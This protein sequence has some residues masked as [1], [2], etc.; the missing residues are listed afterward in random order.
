MQSIQ[1]VLRIAL[2]AATLLLINSHAAFPQGSLTP[3]AAPAPTM[4]SLDQ[5]EARTPIAA[6]PFTI[7]TS[8][9]YYLTKNVSV[10]SGDAI[11]I[12]ANDVTLD[13]NGFTISSTNAN[14]VTGTGILIGNSLHNITISNGH[15]SGAIV[16]SAGSYSGSGFYNGIYFSAGPPQATRIYGV[17]V[18]GCKLNGIDLSSVS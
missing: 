9:S 11:T 14:P 7:T 18:S 12:N 3:Q 6:A 5:I 1:S 8:G 10:A 16:F 17:T 13:L 2:V 4:K 15:I